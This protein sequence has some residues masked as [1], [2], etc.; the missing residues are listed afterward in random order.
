MPALEPTE[1]TG[2]ITWIGRVADRSASLASDPAGTLR[3]GFDGP[4]GEMHGGSI[5]PSCSRVTKQHP[6]GTPI[7]NVRQLSIVSEEELAE[8]AV[9]LGLDRLEPAWIGATL[10]LSGLPD[11]S[12][13]PPSSRLQGPDGA[14]LVVDMLNQPCHL[15][16]PVIRAATGREKL[17]KSFKAA[18]KHRRGITAWVEREGTLS[19]GDVLRLHIPVQPAWPHLE[20]AR[21]A[22]R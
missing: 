16:D 19:P 15:P 10:C 4:E 7:R 1:F 14:T 9:G 18:A 6:R 8:I 3:I 5:R 2:R 13:L 21:A 12:L 17:A 22:S 20:A 11:L